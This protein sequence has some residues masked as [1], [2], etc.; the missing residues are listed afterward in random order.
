MWVRKEVA[1]RRGVVRTL[2]LFSKV[3]NFFIWRHIAKFIVSS[4]TIPYIYNTVLRLSVVYFDSFVHIRVIFGLQANRRI[5]PL[6]AWLCAHASSS[7]A[8]FQQLEVTGFHQPILF[9]AETP[10][11]KFVAYIDPEDKF[12]IEDKLSQVSISMR[13]TLIEI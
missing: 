11:R 3:C 6:R 8:K 4:T 7:L 12:A 2:P 10:L 1:P 5:S 9:Q 13:P